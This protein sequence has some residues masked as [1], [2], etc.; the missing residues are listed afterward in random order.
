M[1]VINL[2]ETGIKL[3]TS[4][5][6]QMYLNLKEVKDFINKKYNLTDNVLK[7]N[8]KELTLSEKDLEEFPDIVEYI[9]TNFN[10]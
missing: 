6:R 9:N 5:K 1:K 3:I 2:D 8:Q 4:T 7:I 10:K